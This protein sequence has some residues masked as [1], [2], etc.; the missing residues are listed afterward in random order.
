MVASP[1]GKLCYAT[2]T[3]NSGGIRKIESIEPHL[4]RLYIALEGKFILNG[5]GLETF[6]ILF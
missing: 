6:I 5:Y 4:M 1:T 3:K 2:Q